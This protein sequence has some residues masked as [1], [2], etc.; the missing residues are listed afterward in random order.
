[1]SE[2]QGMDR[3]SFIRRSAALFAAS[4][5][6]IR[7]VD[8]ARAGDAVPAPSEPALQGFVVA[9][10]HFGWDN[11]VQPAPEAIAESIDRIMA[12][13]PDL[14]LFVDAGDAKPLA[15]ALCRLLTDADL[16]W[17]MGKAGR[18]RVL[19]QFS[20][21]RILGLLLKLYEKT[22]RCKG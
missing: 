16:R 11:P 8:R 6:G 14:D 21:E 15:E 19:D 4:A 20:W 9:D 18:Q 10:A 12:R 13:F 5:A 17:A 3:R 22:V 7:F 1:M 2:M